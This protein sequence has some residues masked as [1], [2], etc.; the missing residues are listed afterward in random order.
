MDDAQGKDGKHFGSLED[1]KCMDEIV[2]E[3]LTG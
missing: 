1:R 3:L 2:E